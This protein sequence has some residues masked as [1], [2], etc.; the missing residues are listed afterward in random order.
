MLDAVFSKY[1]KSNDTMTF[2]DI[3]INSAQ[4]LEKCLKQNALVFPLTA[5]FQDLLTEYNVENKQL[6][7]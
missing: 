4:K 7:E 3:N 5:L 6:V 1:I 2:H